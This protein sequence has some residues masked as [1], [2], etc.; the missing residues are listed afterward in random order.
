MELKKKKKQFRHLHTRSSRVQKFFPFF[1]WV[2]RLDRYGGTCLQS[3][4]AIHQT[5]KCVRG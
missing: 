5:V 2:Y 3:L 1:E 4:I